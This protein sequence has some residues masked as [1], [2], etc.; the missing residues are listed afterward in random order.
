[1]YKIK[2]LFLV[3]FLHKYIIVNI[4]STGVCKYLNFHS[5]VSLKDIDAIKQTCCVLHKLCNNFIQTPN[6]HDNQSVS[7]FH[8]NCVGAV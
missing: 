2:K 3:I 6:I 5:G 8:R 4:F 7:M 1:M